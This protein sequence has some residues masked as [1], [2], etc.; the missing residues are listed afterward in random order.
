MSSETVD[1][2]GGILARTLG[3]PAPEP[4][5]DL[6]E[7]GLLDSLALVELLVAVEQDFGITFAAEE[8]SI[9]RFRSLAALAELVDEHRA[10]AA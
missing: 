8:L 10:E 1:R 3:V 6:V 5:T 4:G 2:V 9:E 7:S